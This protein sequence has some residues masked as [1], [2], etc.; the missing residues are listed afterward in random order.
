MHSSKR[1]SLDE[2]DDLADPPDLKVSLVNVEAG[3]RERD[4]KNS[5]SSHT[6]RF[7]LYLQKRY[8]QP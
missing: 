7:V 5:L 1:N 8:T 4:I 2:G 6:R 3:K